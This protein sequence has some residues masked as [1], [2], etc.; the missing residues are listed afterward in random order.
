MVKKELFKS[1]ANST[2]NEAIETFMKKTDVEI[3]VE[4]NMKAVNKELH[5]KR[6]NKMRQ[7][8][9]ESQREEW[10]YEKIENFIGY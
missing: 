8:L 5:N 1:P 10:K 2:K 3:E 7:I 6:L 9:E 4:K